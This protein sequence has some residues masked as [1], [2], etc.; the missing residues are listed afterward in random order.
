MRVC[1]QI[2]P[3]EV[4]STSFIPLGSQF[5][6]KYDER[7]ESDGGIVYAKAEN[8]W[9]AEV[10]TV[11]PDCSF[12]ARD[13]VLMSQYRGENINFSDGEFTILNETDALMVME[14]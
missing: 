1:N 11:G 13:R 4:P 7:K 5:L 8:T 3:L 2:E 9:W 6:G 14:S 10:V 12:E